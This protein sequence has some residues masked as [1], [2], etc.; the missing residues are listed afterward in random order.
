MSGKTTKSSDRSPSVP[1]VVVHK[2]DC[3]CP[4]CFR[5]RKGKGGIRSWFRKTQTTGAGDTGNVDG[6][7]PDSSG[8]MGVRIGIIAGSLGLVLGGLVGF[9]VGHAS[10]DGGAGTKSNS[11]KSS[12]SGSSSKT[13]ECAEWRTSYGA[14]PD[15]YGNPTSRQTCVRWK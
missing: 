9:G 4:D 7:A 15:P 13:T 10:S 14:Y 12:S 6:L 5:A 1:D 2:P 3:L 11:S 8:G